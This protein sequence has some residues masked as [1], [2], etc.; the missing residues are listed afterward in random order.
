MLVSGGGR[1]RSVSNPRNQL[2]PAAIV[3]RSRI[4]ALRKKLLLCS[5]LAV[6]VVLRTVG[7][8]EQTDRPALR[9]GRTQFEVEVALIDFAGGEGQVTSGQVADSGFV[10]AHAENGITKQ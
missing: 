2:Q 1:R 6:V 4:A 9:E 8:V 7:L 10:G 5:G 3:L